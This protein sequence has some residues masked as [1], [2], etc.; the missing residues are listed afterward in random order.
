MYQVITSYIKYDLWNNN[1]N[2]LKPCISSWLLQRENSGVTVFLK[3]K[4]LKVHFQCTVNVHGMSHNK[5]F[6]SAKRI[7]VI[8]ISILTED[9][10]LIIKAF[11]FVLSCFVL[12]AIPLALDTWKGQML[13]LES[14]GAIKKV[15]QERRADFKI[16]IW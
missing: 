10:K 6:F 2:R 7:M 9:P 5:I 3:W 14:F 16:K 15:K 11:C 13:L 4:F 1:G 8:S 12:L